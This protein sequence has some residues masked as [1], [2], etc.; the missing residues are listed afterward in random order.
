[1]ETEDAVTRSRREA[2]RAK[3]VPEGVA[4][5]ANAEVVAKRDARRVAEEN[6]MVFL[7]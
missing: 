7:F 1:L 2:E 5:G 4:A 6:F 3:I